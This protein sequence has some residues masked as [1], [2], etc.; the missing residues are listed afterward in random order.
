MRSYEEFQTEVAD[1]SLSDDERTA[2]LRSFWLGEI[3]P[4][5]CADP[6]AAPALMER[7]F[8]EAE[9]SFAHADYANRE[10]EGFDARDKLES[11]A[12]R[13]LVVAG[14]HDTLPVEMSRAIA[15]TLADSEF[16]LFENSGHHAPAEEPERFEKVL[17]EFL[18]ERP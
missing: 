2:M 13:S 4:A 6:E 16:V 8:G 7:L 17:L 12:T 9:F 14:E 15:E 1:E 10:L 5:S 18:G 3:F 11:I